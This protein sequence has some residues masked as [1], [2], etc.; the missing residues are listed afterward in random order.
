MTAKP[1]STQEPLYGTRPENPTRPYIRPASSK[2]AWLPLWAALGFLALGGVGL[3]VY[4]AGR[5]STRPK[6]PT[7]RQRVEGLEAIVRQHG[8]LLVDTRRFVVDSKAT[9]T[10]AAVVRRNRERTDALVAT[11]NAETT[12]TFAWTLGVMRLQMLR[13]LE[14]VEEQNRGLRKLILMGRGGDK[15][16]TVIVGTTKGDK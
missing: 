3:L 4:D 11:L 10:L 13:R 9:D 2:S 6:P 5:R 16:T 15:P 7:L 14:F 12:G 1:P 8:Q